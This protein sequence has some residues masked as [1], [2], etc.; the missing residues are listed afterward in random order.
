MSTTEA[1]RTLRT[2]LIEVGDTINKAA[3]GYEAFANRARRPEVSKQAR[4]DAGVLRAIYR[5][6]KRALDEAAEQAA[7][8]KDSET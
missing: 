3:D 8:T 7:S 4:A 1:I 5:Q 6:T 2:A